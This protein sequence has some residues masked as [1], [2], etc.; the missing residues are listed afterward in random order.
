M[1]RPRDTFLR[2]CTLALACSLLACSPRSLLGEACGEGTVE[3]NGLC[4]AD[5]GLAC[6]AGTILVGRQCVLP[7]AGDGSTPRDD[8]GAVT[9]CG[10][11]TH[12]EGDSCIADADA[13]PTCG[14]G[15][16]LSGD[17][18]VPNADAGATC[19]PGTVLSGGVCVPAPDAGLSCGPGTVLSGNTCVPGDDAGPACGPGTLDQNGVCVPIV[20]GGQP[21]Y[22]VLVPYTQIVAD[23]YSDLPVTVIGTRP[24]G[25]PA[26]DPVQL[27]VSVSGVA[28]FIAPQFTL[29][30]AGYLAQLVP[31]KGC[32]AS[33]QINLA[34]Q[35]DPNTVIAQSPFL[36]LVPESG[37]GSDA[38]CLVEGNTF[39]LNSNAP[40]GRMLTGMLTLADTGVVITEQ[41]S[42]TP[43]KIGLYIV[44]TNPARRDLWWIQFD[45]LR[46]GQPLQPQIYLNAQP[47]PFA[48][49]G[50]AGIDIAGNGYGCGPSS[51]AFQVEDIAYDGGTLTSFTA[52]FDLDC[53]VNAPALHGCVHYE[54]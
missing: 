24:D 45:S 35:S 32:V 33:F 48:A 40:G 14:A 38:E 46:L 52:S 31:C 10:P 43:A 26:L 30:A 53:G 27:T 2:A 1:T 36:Q 44:S 21:A 41:S 5:A 7:D 6:S 25:T 22:Q 8:A 16:H 4:I 50:H 23:G 18:C 15:T 51:A 28:S 54:P 3:M 39:F 17:S 13:G 12:G 19:G 11:G 42:S 29:G 34:L 47:S 20:S 37:I 49:P 9:A